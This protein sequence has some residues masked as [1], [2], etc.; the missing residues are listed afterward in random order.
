MES[1]E[2][3]PDP[4]CVFTGTMW[5][6]RNREEME[7]LAQQKMRSRKNPKS[8][9]LLA[10]LFAAGA[11]GLWCVG[12]SGGKF[13]PGP[14]YPR[15]GEQ[16]AHYGPWIFAAMLVFSFIAVYLVRRFDWPSSDKK[17]TEVLICPECHIAQHAH[18][19]RCSCGVNLEPLEHWKWVDA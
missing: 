17:G 8:A 6:R 15:S 9:L 3:Q 13:K 7:H 18:D 2:A 14:F 1:G 11:F 5:Q 10:S 16:I 12:S 19:R 4:L